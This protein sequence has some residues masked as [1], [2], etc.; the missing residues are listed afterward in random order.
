ME[1]G[2]SASS[3]ATEKAAELLKQAEQLADRLGSRTTVGLC[4]MIGAVSAV[5]DGRSEDAERYAIEAEGIL[6][7]QS[8][9][10]AWPLIIARVYHISA[11]IDEGKIVDLCRV[12]RE[13]LDDAQDRGNLFAATMF[14]SGWSTLLWLCNDDLDGAKDALQKALT[15]CPEGVFYIPHYNC[16]L[17]RGMID[18]YAGENEAAFKHIEAVWPTLERSLVLRIRSVRVR[19]LRMRAAC[20]IA[21]ANNG[22]DREGLLAIAEN[23]AK[24]LERERH[25]SVISNNAKARLLRAGISA[26]RG[27]M[28]TA[29]DHL[30]F[31]IDQFKECGS[32]FWYAISMRR[33]GQMIGGDEGKAMMRQADDWMWCEKIKNPARMTAAFI[34]GFPLGKE[35]VQTLRIRTPLSMRESRPSPGEGCD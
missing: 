1:A 29:V 24:A 21:A 8:A 16:L 4:R 18:L 14:R 9:L 17:A 25:Y 31:A 3:G 27:D 11:L 5:H 30:S 33:K 7:E 32:E 13:F 12:S 2:F 20:A 23:H 35:S 19:C 34:P 28:P 10:S 26:T 22:G 6:S 15:Q